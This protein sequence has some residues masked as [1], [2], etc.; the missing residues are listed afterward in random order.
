MQTKVLS[1]LER[2]LHRGCAFPRVWSPGPSACSVPRL[3]VCGGAGPTTRSLRKA[4]RSHLLLGVGQERACLLPSASPLSQPPPLYPSPIQSSAQD[5]LQVV[6]RWEEFP[7]M[8]QAWNPPHVPRRPLFHL[9]PVWHTLPTWLIYSIISDFSGE[10]PGN[11]FFPK[12]LSSISFPT[13]AL[14]DPSSTHLSPCFVFLIIN[15][16]FVCRNISSTM[17]GSVTVIR[18]PCLSFLSCCCV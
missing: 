6:E 5:L 16:G 11:S 8:S 15:D 7:T 18:I 13:I 10:L 12:G 14:T 1:K 17:E 2:V 9:C 4:P 3:S